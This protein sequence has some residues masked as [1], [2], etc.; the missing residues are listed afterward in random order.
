[1]IR[2]FPTGTHFSPLFP[3]FG[4]FLVNAEYV[5]DLAAILLVV[6]AGVLLVFLAV[7]AV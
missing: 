3:T 7:N 6:L 2:V 4:G 1:M 5:L